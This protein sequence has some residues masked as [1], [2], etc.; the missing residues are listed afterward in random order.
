MNLNYTSDKE[1]FISHTSLLRS[2]KNTL[3]LF[4]FTVVL[5]ASTVCAVGNSR[6]VN[7]Q[8]WLILEENLSSNPLENDAV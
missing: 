5:N 3:G 8:A 6:T 1:N 7:K 2:K 4:C